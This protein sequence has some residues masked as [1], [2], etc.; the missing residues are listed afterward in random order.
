M[1]KLNDRK[2]HQLLQ[3]LLSVR[4]QHLDRCRRGRI[5]NDAHP[6]RLAPRWQSTGR[7]A[8]SSR[9]IRGPDYSRLQILLSVVISLREM[10]PHAE[11]ED[12]TTHPRLATTV[13]PCHPRIPA[14]REQL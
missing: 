5:A 13:A 11:R 12:Y 7:C 1:P 8:G 9:D 14:F 6:G 4:F 3:R 2:E 10:I